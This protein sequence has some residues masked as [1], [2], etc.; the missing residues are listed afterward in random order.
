MRQFLKAFLVAALALATALTIPAQRAAAPAARV[1]VP[2]RFIGT[3]PAVEVMVNGKGPF[4]FGIDTGA[5]G[6]ARLDSAVAEKLGIKPAGDVQASDGSG[7]GPQ[8]MQMVRLESIELAGLRFSDV[9][10]G[11]RNYKASPRSATM[12]GI[13]GLQLFAGYLVTLDFPGKVVR[14]DRGELPE[15]DGK[16]ILDYKNEGGV[17]TVDLFV[18]AMRM[19][20]HFDSGNS[21]GAF[22]LPMALV[23][24]LDLASEATVVG[25]ARSLS[26]D[27]E[28]RQA[29]LKESI[30][31][32]SH[33]FADP[34]ITFPALGEAAN[35]GAKSLESFALTFDQRNNRLRLVRNDAGKK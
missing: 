27:V 23:E 28:I 19:S 18:G 6:Q 7:R 17:P 24:K 4:L 13:I 11:S 1:E 20:A 34:T 26:G 30:R 29:R 10:A 33:E 14:L 21:I 15:A 8:R 32:G 9:S 25:K 5:Q 31:L 2:M 16:A 22:V 3:M 12:D 35:I